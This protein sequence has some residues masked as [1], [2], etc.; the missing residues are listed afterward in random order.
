DIIKVLD[1]WERFFRREM[2]L[3]VFNNKGVIKGYHLSKIKEIINELGK[4]K[5]LV[6]KTNTNKR[7]ALENLLLQI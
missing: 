1:V 7:L 6:E 4:T 3:N 5:Y 2:L